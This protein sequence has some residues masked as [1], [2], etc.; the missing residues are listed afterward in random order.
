V[1]FAYLGKGVGDNWDSWQEKLHYIDYA[2]V[3]AIVG[4]VVYLLWRRRRR[5]SGDAEPSA[6]APA[7]DSLQ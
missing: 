7:A 6:A 4:G 5:G 2:I 3:A 1:A